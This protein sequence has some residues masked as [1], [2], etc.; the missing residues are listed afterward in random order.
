[1]GRLDL[2]KKRENPYCLLRC[3]GGGREDDKGLD[4]DLLGLVVASELG[5]R[6]WI[7][8]RY[9]CSTSSSSSA[10]FYGE[11]SAPAR[12]SGAWQLTAG[13]AASPLILL[14]EELPVVALAFFASYP[15]SSRRRC[16]VGGSSASVS[17]Y[18]PSSF[19]KQ[20]VE[21]QRFHLPKWFVPGGDGFS[22]E[23]RPLV[24]GGLHCNLVFSFGVLLAKFVDPVVIFFLWGPWMRCTY[25]CL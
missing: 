6:R 13:L 12:A 14:A 22:S 20:V 3:R 18:A 23:L 5:V 16:H 7:R 8:S 9:N 10:T 21:L 17:T 2:K 19:I 1:M 4:L 24:A 15:S 11:A 25:C